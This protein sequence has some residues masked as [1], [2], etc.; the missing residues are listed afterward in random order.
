MLKNYI[1][2]YSDYL[3]A[4]HDFKDYLE[5]RAEKIGK[6]ILSKKLNKS[7]SYLTNI[8]KRDGTHKFWIEL[9]KQ[10]SEVENEKL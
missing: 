4:K 6:S 2:R 7:E 3:T 9:E 1:K 5:H 8:F 10:I